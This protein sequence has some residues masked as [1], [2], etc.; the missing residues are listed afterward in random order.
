MNQWPV[1]I[2]PTIDTTC[3]YYSLGVVEIKMHQ[4]MDYPSNKLAKDFA[5]ILL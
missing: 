1:H 3:T 4:F 2:L 5:L